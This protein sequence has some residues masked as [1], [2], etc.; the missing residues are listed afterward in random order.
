[1]ECNWIAI[2]LQSSINVPWTSALWNVASDIY[3]F[4]FVLTFR[5]GIRGHRCRNEKPAIAAF[6]I[7]QAAIGTYIAGKPSRSG[8]TTV[9]AHPLIL[10]GFHLRYLLFTSGP[11]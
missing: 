3:E 4:P 8:I 1:M 5:A 6:P 9:R 2:I 10:L 7:G 11:L